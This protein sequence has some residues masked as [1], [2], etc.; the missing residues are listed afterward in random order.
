MPAPAPCI[1]SSRTPT[2]TATP[3]KVL[4]FPHSGGSAG[5]YQDLASRLTGIAETACVE[6]PGRGE[7][8][9]E[10]LF[11][12]VHALADEVAEAF[13]A[14]RKDR[15][16]ILFGHSLGATVAYEV[17]RRSPDHQHLTL[18]ASG[19]VAPSRLNLP[20]MNDEGPDEPLIELVS[21]LG[22]EAPAILDH[23]VL[24]QL[25]LPVI[26][27]DLSAHGRYLPE[28]G[29]AISCPVIAL[30]GDADPLTNAIDVHAWQHHTSSEFRAHT[31]AGDH[32][33]TTQHSEAVADILRAAMTA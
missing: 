11:T 23:P 18:V 25:F 5:S 20:P 2:S 26:H 21:S 16:V 19:H 6:Y 7:R 9:R 8:R 27:S 10:P 15:P 4:F 31:F 14:W 13:A 17:I 33:F 3:W 22:G 24:R 29:S 32:F 30:R 1:R 28:P 12:D